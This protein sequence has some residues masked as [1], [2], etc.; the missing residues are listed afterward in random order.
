MSSFDYRPPFN[1]IA[2]YAKCRIFFTFR[3]SL[4]LPQWWRHSLVP[5]FPSSPWPTW[6]ASCGLFVEAS[7]TVW[8]FATFLSLTNDQIRIEQ[9][10]LCKTIS[11]KNFCSTEK[12]PA[13]SLKVWPSDELSSGE[14]SLKMQL[15][16]GDP[17][18]CRLTVTARTAT[19]TASRKFWSGL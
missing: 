1:L 3:T 11:K 4:A 14:S 13:G 19:K 5:N 9:T 17:T 12:V 18:V 7:P 6:N 16:C 10:N 2:L 8:N 15:L